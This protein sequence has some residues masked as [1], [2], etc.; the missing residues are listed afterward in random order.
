[1]KKGQNNLDEGENQARVKTG[2]RFSAKKKDIFRR[3]PA[4]WG[5]KFEENTEDEK[6]TLTS[7]RSRASGPEGERGGTLG[8]RGEGGPLFKDRRPS[9]Y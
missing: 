1:M 4:I 9:G 7:F 3:G 6:Y 2:G 8:E 5:G